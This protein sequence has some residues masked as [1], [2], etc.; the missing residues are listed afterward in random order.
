MKNE[1]IRQQNTIGIIEIICS[2]RKSNNGSQQIQL[3]LLAG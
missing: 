3:C 2:K 1:E